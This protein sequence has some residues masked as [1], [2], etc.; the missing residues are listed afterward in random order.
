MMRSSNL[1]LVSGLP[2]SGKTTFAKKQADYVLIDDPR[3]KPILEE[4]KK[5][6]I[7]DPNFCKRKVFDSV[8]RL[9]PEA[10]WVFFTTDPFISWTSVVERQK[11]EPKKV[12]TLKEFI[13]FK[14]E[15]FANLSYYK[16]SVKSYQEE[17]YY[18]LVRGRDK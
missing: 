10:H 4:G 16:K 14:D 11:Q 15:F 12:I 1:V 6:I 18:A 17:K 2:G 13:R 3:E 7:T 5:Y 9:Y 8:N